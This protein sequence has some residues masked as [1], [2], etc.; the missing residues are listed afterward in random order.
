MQIRRLFNQGGCFKCDQNRCDQCK[1]YV[2]QASNF[3]SSATGRQYPIRQELSCSSKNVIYLATCRECNL[4]YVDSTSTEF[5]VRFRNHKSSMLTYHLP[6]K[7]IRWRN[8]LQSIHT[9]L[10]RDVNSARNIVLTTTTYYAFSHVL[11]G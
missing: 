10:T 2:L 9:V 6:G 7:P 3:Q 4:W 8:Y 1:N 5:K 11:A